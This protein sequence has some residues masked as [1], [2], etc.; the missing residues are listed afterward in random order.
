MSPRNR[1]SPVAQVP[2]LDSARS[3]PG[4]A[5]RREQAVQD[6]D[7]RPLV[8]PRPL[9]EGRLPEFLVERL[10]AQIQ[11][12]MEINNLSTITREVVETARESLVIGSL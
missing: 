8:K 5:V 6:P 12:I 9:P 10:F 7:G 1:N 3:L 11:R 4:G 2:G